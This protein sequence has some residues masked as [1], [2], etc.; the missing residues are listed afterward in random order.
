[1]IPFT[2]IWI[3]SGLLWFA[4]RKRKKRMKICSKTLLTQD[5]SDK[6][7]DGKEYESSGV[8]VTRCSN[9]GGPVVFL[10]SSTSSEENDLESQNISRDCPVRVESSLRTLKRP[11]T[12][13]LKQNSLAPPASKHLSFLE[14]TRLANP[15]VKDTAYEKNGVTFVTTCNRSEQKEHVHKA[16]KVIKFPKCHSFDGVPASAVAKKILIKSNRESP[17]CNEPSTLAVQILTPLVSRRNDCSQLSSTSTSPTPSS[18]VGV[19]HGD[20]LRNPSKQSRRR[21]SI[22]RAK[23]FMMSNSFESNVA[24][25]LLMVVFTLSFS[26]LPM[27]ITFTHISFD[28]SLSKTTINNNSTTAVVVIVILL[29]NSLWNCLIYGAKTRY[30]RAAVRKTINR[31]MSYDQNNF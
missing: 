25:S 23:E 16:S 14:K 18:P 2:L 27:L 29:S 6:R 12:L 7:T 15:I 28:Q 4:L 9:A 11:Q 24:K 17:S 3:F 1:M 20:I 13:N 31:L 19:R 26:V 30:F 10:V 8:M 22:F 21:S 5:A